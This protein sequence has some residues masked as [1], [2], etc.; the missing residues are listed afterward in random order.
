MP[1]VYHRLKASLIKLQVS[2][3]RQVVS[4]CGL[5]GFVAIIC[6]SAKP[7][8]SIIFFTSTPDK[9]SCSS[10]TTQLLALRIYVLIGSVIISG[11]PVNEEALLLLN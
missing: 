7:T 8:I 4:V 9:D 11:I 1:T 6:S 2:D 5:P 3:N 10:T